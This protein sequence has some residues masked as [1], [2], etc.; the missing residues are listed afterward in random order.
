MGNGKHRQQIIAEIYDRHSSEFYDYHA[1]RGDVE[2]YVALATESG[3]P[4][5]EIGCGTGRLLIP[6]ARAG[7]HITGLDNS[8]EM[9]EIC[10]RKLEDEP[11]KV[12]GRVNQ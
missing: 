3:G 11:T 10:R 8:E 9:L 1:K 2:F 7:V 5:L 6:T 12:K 4:V